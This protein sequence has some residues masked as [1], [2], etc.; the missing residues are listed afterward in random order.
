MTIALVNYGAGNLFSVKSALEELDVKPI[1]ATSP[2]HIEAASKIILPGVG[3]FPWVKA[4]L[5]E[6]GLWSAISHKLETGTPYL[7]I[8]LGM[9]LLACRSFEGGKPISGFGVIDGDIRP[10]KP[11]SKEDR[12]PNIGWRVVNW[13]EGILFDDFKKNEAVYYFCHGYEFVGDQKN[14]LATALYNGGMVAAIR[15]EHVFG[16]QFHPERSGS[17]GLNLLEEFIDYK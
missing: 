12:V 7:G 9:H 3:A 11:T 17:L 1:D 13:H 8:C 2:G 15:K 4:R 14:V 6:R 10:I 5:V 16:V